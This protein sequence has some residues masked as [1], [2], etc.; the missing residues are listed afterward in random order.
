MRAKTLVD[1]IEKP[2]DKSPTLIIQNEDRKK[3]SRRGILYQSSKIMGS[4]D[5]DKLIKKK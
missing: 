3:Q 2:K 1:R 4:K 5:N